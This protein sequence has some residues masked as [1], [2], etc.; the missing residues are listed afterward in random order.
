MNMMHSFKDWS[1][2]YRIHAIHREDISKLINNPVFWVVITL[3]IF[4]TVL[5]AVS[6]FTPATNQTLPYSPYPIPGN[7][8]MYPPVR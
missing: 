8:P 1:G 7:W 6:L 2:Q 5:V 3:L 4:L